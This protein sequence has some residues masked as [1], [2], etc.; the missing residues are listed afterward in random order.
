[1]A[2]LLRGEAHWKEFITTEGMSCKDIPVPISCLPWGDPPLSTMW[3]HHDTVAHHTLSW[4]NKAKWPRTQTQRII[5]QTFCQSDPRWQTQIP[6]LWSKDMSHIQSA[7]GRWNKNPWSHQSNDESQGSQP[8]FVW[9]GW[10][11][12]PS[13]P[14]SWNGN[15]PDIFGSFRDKAPKET[16]TTH[17]QGLQSLTLDL[18]V[19]PDKQLDVG[20]GARV[21]RDPDPSF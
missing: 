8:S 10:P 6:C 7:E 16:L 14:I 2:A 18:V 12:P 21:G 20:K 13:C 5:T 15:H 1:M 3:S 17:H 11:F 4:I 9:S 19:N